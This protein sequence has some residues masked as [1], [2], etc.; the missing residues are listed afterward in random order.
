MIDFMVI[1]LPRS[2]STW[3]ANWLTTGPV[4]CKHDPLYA[5][6]YEEFDSKIVSN[7][8]IQGI[9]CTGL[10]RWADWV[11]KHPAKK[12]ILHRDFPEV[13]QSMRDIGFPALDEDAID[14]IDSIKGL[15]V[16]YRS[17]FDPAEAKKLW[18]Y[19]VGTE[20]DEYRHRELVDIE[21]QPKF[22][23]LKV[24]PEATRRLISEIHAAIIGD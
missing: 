18:A 8:E 7:A 16:D 14:M 13:Q 12:L 11:N 24:N 3:A 22:I 4:F 17:L 2:G 15:H 5:M 1:S 6:H 9:S 21:M 20:F 23:G 10:W 19:L